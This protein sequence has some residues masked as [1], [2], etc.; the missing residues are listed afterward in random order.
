MIRCVHTTN[1]P[2]ACTQR[3]TLH[4]ICT[5]AYM[6]LAWMYISATDLHDLY[7]YPSGAEALFDDAHINPAKCREWL[8]RG[9]P[10]RNLHM[11]RGYFKY[12]EQVRLITC[13]LPCSA[14]CV[15]AHKKAHT[16]TCPPS[17]VAFRCARILCPPQPHVPF[18]C[19]C[20]SLSLQS[21]TASATER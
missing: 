20:H 7:K 17:I 9:M 15:C 12:A 11:E 5:H 2:C 16:Q 21:K 19:S 18:A 8:S 1:R 4:T 6:Q 3:S 14:T 10:F 13:T